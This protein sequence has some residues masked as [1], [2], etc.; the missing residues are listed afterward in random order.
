VTFVT[1]VRLSHSEA[2]AGVRFVAMESGLAA[3][4]VAAIPARGRLAPM[5]SGSGWLL[6]SAREL[7]RDRLGLYECA[8]RSDGDV[9]RFPIGPPRRRFE[10]HGVFHP[11][12]VQRVLAGSRG[13][14]S[15][16][17][18]FVRGLGR[19][20]LVSEGE[21][22]QR[23]RRVIQPL[24]TRRA[25]AGYATLMAEEASVAA[26]RWTSGG[27]VAPEVDA[28]AE[29][30]RL[31]LRVV[32]R[33]IFGDDVDEARDVLGSAFPVVTRWTFR[34]AMSPVKLP[35][36]WPT[37]A[38]VRAARRRELYG[39]VDG[40]IAR[41][42]AAGAAGEDL[43]SRL[44]C[45]RDPDSGAAM[46]EQ[47]VRDEA[48]TFVVAGH[49]TTAIALTF[50]LD[51]LGRHAGEQ[52]LVREEVD[53]VLGGRA[54]GVDDVAA[55][56]RVAMA[57]KEAMRLYPPAPS[58][59]R[60][61]EVE[62]EIGGFRIPAGAH[63]VVSPWA[64]HRHPAFWEDPDV[65][66][67]SRFAPEREAARHRYAYFPFGGGPRAC[68]GSHFALMEAVIAVAVIL[69]RFRLRAGQR[70]PPLET[71]GITLRPARPVPIALAPR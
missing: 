21:L 57:V 49:E 15:K 51:L 42:R 8:M 56:E 69:Q 29:M 19:G 11:D 22:W 18:R 30:T 7:R 35:A 26:E 4:G 43:V 66:D 6:G 1:F 48:L 60:R 68:I 5:Y 9:V 47:Q 16:R 14:Y 13:R 39:V 28:H 34:R 64:T 25:I 2:T 61:A 32:G 58:W 23:Q 20:L 10:I 12:G 59:G 63:V 17:T 40:L 52:E 67:P 3:E 62:D 54:P 27:S 65:F 44:L 31:T 53:R 33:A 46:D 36:S 41:R 24:F 37:P 71:R 38:N 55:L 45:A 50:A 70:R